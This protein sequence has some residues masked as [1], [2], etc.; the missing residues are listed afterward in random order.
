MK[1]LVLGFALV[2]GMIG[3][4]Q[5]NN[6]S[7]DYAYMTES[8]YFL[9]KEY[10][11]QYMSPAGRFQIYNNKDKQLMRVYKKQLNLAF[12]KFNKWN[13]KYFTS[14]P[15][16]LDTIMMSNNFYFSEQFFNNCPITGYVRIPINK[17]QIEYIEIVEFVNKIVQ[18]DNK[19]RHD[20]V[21]LIKY[22]NKSVEIYLDETRYKYNNCAQCV[23]YN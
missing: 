4:A 5:E 15:D 23:V 14:N 17:D 12:N 21:I 18:F 6:K 20:F 3:N 22:E 13:N 10:D 11:I 16:L 7:Y 19:L 9:L 1:K 2:I 8:Q